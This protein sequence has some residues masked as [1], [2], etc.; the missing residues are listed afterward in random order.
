MQE[1][2]W[3]LQ[4]RYSIYRLV[5]TA[6]SQTLQVAARGTDL[7]NPPR[8][9]FERKDTTTIKGKKTV[10]VT[11]CSP[12]GTG[13]ALEYKTYETYPRAV[14]AL[15]SKLGKQI[16]QLIRRPAPKVLDMH[17]SAFG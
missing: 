16:R 5:A 17:R 12:G 1:I 15:A 11:G 4:A 9:L 6:L 13:H 3:T 14:A 2:L 10:L 7:L 8:R